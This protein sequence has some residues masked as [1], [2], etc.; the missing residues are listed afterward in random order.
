MVALASGTKERES[1]VGCTPT[2]CTP[3]TCSCKYDPTPASV[4]AVPA[5]MTAISILPSV[6]STSSGPVVL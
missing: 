1:G 5:N 6:S 3:G 2:I 4:P